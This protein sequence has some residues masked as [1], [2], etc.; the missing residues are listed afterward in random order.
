MS[1]LDRKGYE[2]KISRDE[3]SHVANL[4]RLDF[5]DDEIETLTGQ[6]NSILDYIDKLGELNTEDVEPTYHAVPVT[7]AF[8]ED[9]RK[10]EF[11]VDEALANAPDSE[12]GNFK[13]PK[14][15]E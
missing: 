7:N 10:R 2:V 15:L 3:V 1:R 8:R 11:S 6:M 13:V 12:E 9:E 5:G 14:V 4:A